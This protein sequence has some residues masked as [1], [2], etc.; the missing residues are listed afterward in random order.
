MQE[1][2]KQFTI[3]AGGKVNID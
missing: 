2:K 3:F 1:A